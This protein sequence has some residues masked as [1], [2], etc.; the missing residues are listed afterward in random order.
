MKKMVLK[1]YINYFPDHIKQTS[2]LNK[3][4]M[5]SVETHSLRKGND[6]NYSSMASQALV[7][8]TTNYAQKSIR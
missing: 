6:T 4:K 1:V 7:L 2:S 3:I 8:K 5:H